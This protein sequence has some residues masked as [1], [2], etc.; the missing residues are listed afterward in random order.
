[1]YFEGLYFK[2]RLKA[3]NQ[4]TNMAMAHTRKIFVLVRRHSAKSEKVL[5]VNKWEA[6]YNLI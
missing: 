3:Q 1:M 6:E 5:Y 2:K 4:N